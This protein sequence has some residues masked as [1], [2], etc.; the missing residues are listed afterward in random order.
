MK[1]LILVAALI[2]AAAVG[3]YFSKE[4]TPQ[5]AFGPQAV[6]SAPIFDYYVLALSWSPTYCAEADPQGRSLQCSA[7]DNKKYRFIVHG[8]WPNKKKGWD[9][10]CPLAPGESEKVD[11]RIISR[12]FKHMPSE[13]LITH[14]WNKH[15]TCSGLTQ[16]DY[17]RTLE[18][19]FKRYAPPAEYQK[20]TAV[21]TVSPAALVRD[22]TRAH[23]DKGL[24]PES[25]RVYCRR[26]RLREVRLCLNKDLSPTPCGVN[27]KR[28]CRQ[29]VITLPPAR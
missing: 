22:F 2:A 25:V 26:D 5:P 21:K 4:K 6:K 18:D 1:R 8:L 14:Q 10:F 20:L 15:G 9:S 27:E 29:D 28:F 7:R 23:A 17:F 19:A 11:G 24:T 13:K 3:M 16:A 12:L